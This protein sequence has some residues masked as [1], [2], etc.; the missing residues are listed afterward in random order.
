[1]VLL[2]RPVVLLLLLFD[3]NCFIKFTGTEEK[4]NHACTK[5]QCTT[6]ASLASG[7]GM[8]TAAMECVC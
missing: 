6:G 8:L 2:T 3:F 7:T 4:K 1:M 5:V